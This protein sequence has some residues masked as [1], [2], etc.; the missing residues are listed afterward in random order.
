MKTK[1]RI[2]KTI[3]FS[4]ILFYIISIISLYSTL[5]YMS[6]SNNI[7]NKQIG[8]YIIGF[9]IMSIIFFIKTENL[10]KYGFYIYLANIFLLIYVLIF[11]SYIN[12]SRAW[13]QIPIIGNIQPS[14]FMKIGLILFLAKILS[15]NIKRGSSDLIII[16]K[17]I[18]IFLIPTIFTFL[19]PDTGAVINF[20]VITIAM[21]F[22]SGIKKRWFFIL[23]ISIFLILFSI[24]YLFYFE[25]ELFINILGSNFFYRLDRIFD[26]TKSSGIQL[27]NSVISISSSGI[28]GHG[29]N[30]IPIYFP[31]LH[32]DFIFAVFVSC[33]GLV[34]ALILFILFYIFDAEIINIGKNKNM[35]FKLI[36]SGI[37]AVLIYQQV[38]NTAMTIGILPI[39]GITLPFISYGGS[40]L[41]SFMILIGIILNIDKQT[42][43]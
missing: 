4:L 7:L 2:N 39:T 17:S 11:G 33:Y 12:G 13:I 10:I 40:S 35:P 24:L 34:G 41:L 25:K 9:F 27:E 3:I 15:D 37:V 28:T 14:E 18:V 29:F 30:K 21:L 19:E 31:E 22:I 8:F 23:F 38:Q 16:L 6:V 32:T 42:T 20:F 26:W 5:D 43:S 1:I 36:S